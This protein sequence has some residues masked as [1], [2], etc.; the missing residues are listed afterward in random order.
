MGKYDLTDAYILFKYDQNGMVYFMLDTITFPKVPLDIHR[1]NLPLEFFTVWKP[2]D[3][4]DI[5][6]ELRLLVECKL[7]L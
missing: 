3:S 5:P 1:G 4:D 7:D 6:E 2:I